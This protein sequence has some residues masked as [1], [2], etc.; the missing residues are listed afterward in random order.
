MKL[1]TKVTRTAS[2]VVLR[3]MNLLKIELAGEEVEENITREMSGEEE[4][5]RMAK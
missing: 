3:K 1:V 5:K 4:R 2:S